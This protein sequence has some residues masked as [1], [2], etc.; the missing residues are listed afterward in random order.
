MCLSKLITKG[1]PLKVETLLWA[2]FMTWLR[3]FFKN[4][5]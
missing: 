3:N 2:Y 1:R 5:K 4:Q